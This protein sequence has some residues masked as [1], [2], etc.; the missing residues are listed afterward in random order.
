MNARVD[1]GTFGE[2]G[3]FKAALNK[4]RNLLLIKTQLIGLSNDDHKSPIYNPQS[5]MICIRKTSPNLA[6]ICK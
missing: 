3:E 5:Y 1:W 6:E 2:W 4:L